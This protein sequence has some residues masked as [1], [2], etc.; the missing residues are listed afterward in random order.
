MQQTH[1]HR[2]VCT[3]LHDLHS[4]G[5]VGYLWEGTL[6]VVPQI[7]PHVA[8]Y[9]RYIIHILA[10]HG[11]GCVIHSI[12]MKPRG[13]LIPT[14]SCGISSNHRM[15][16]VRAAACSA[17]MRVLAEGGFWSFLSS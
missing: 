11:R 1:G 4:K 3:A 13:G 7:F 5:N 16:S 10:A 14:S 2:D 15:S 17:E 9:N 12:R 6:G 8:L